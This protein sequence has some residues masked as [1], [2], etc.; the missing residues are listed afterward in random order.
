MRARSRR[1]AFVGLVLALAL[2]SSGCFQIR[3]FK[4]EGRYSLETTA[5]ADQTA[6]QVDLY[7]MAL[8]TALQQNDRIVLLI[9]LQNLDFRLMQ[10][11]DP[12]GNWG[13]PYTAVRNDAIATY[14]RQGDNC[15]ANGIEAS[16]ITGM[17]WLGF[18]SPGNVTAM[19]LTWED[20]ADVFRIRFRVA[21]PAETDD[22]DYGSVV[23]FSAGWLESD[24][25]GIPED[26]ELV[27]TGMV[28]FSV[29]F[30]PDS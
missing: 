3:M 11:W 7:P 12:A 20:L 14:L 23:V 5:P 28:A 26:D 21:R 27:C 15:T 24:G 8:A 29:P 4:I 6:V 17:E 19:G 22:F 18:A 16:D 1:V 13:G 25:D 2:V 30:R 9:G 10:Q